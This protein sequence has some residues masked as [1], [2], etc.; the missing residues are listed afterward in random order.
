[1]IIKLFTVISLISVSLFASGGE[2]GGNTDIIERTFNFVIFAGIIYYLI[3]DPLKNFLR[4]RTDSIKKEYDK[5]QERLKETETAKKE[6]EDNLAK[7]KETAKVIV[8]DAQKEAETLKR[9]LENSL[10]QDIA[11]IEKQHQNKIEF[12]Q[13]LIKREIVNEVIDELLAKDNIGLDQKS[14][15]QAV[16]SKVS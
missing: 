2:H 3:A 10:E 15:T 11:T 6:A 7:A 5:V 13:N 14:L 8:A 4:N 9:K 12:E 16:I 1:M